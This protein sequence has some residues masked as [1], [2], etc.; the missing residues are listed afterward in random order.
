MALFSASLEYIDEG[1]IVALLLVGIGGSRGESAR[2][3]KDDTSGGKVILDSLRSLVS[4]TFSGEGR[5]EGAG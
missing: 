2:V 1:L 3:M 4:W 5:S